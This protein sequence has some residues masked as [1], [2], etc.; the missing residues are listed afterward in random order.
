MTLLKS[1]P[2]AWARRLVA[3]ALALSACAGIACGQTT[4]VASSPFAPAGSSAAAGGPPAEAYDLA[5]SSIEGST[6]LVC[7]FDRQAKHSEWIPVGGV[8][9]TIHVIS[10]DRLHDKAVVTVSG[11]RK[12]LGLR[13]APVVAAAPFEM[14]MPVA[15]V[16]PPVLN[17]GP[18]Q[19]LSPETKASLAHDQ[20]EARMLVSD[21][22]EI[23]VQQ[24]KAYQEAKQKAASETPAQPT[25]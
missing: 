13:N 10:Y 15:S 25:N 17:P 2:P 23:G 12:E 6:V 5:G 4:L 16:N 24:R 19:P 11:A 1:P 21:L 3:S 22:L 14:P 9:G 7:I 20:N 8:S 18:A